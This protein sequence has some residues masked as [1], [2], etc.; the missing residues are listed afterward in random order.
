MTAPT[1]AVERRAAEPPWPA[2]WNIC[3]AKKMMELIP[4]SCWNMGR[5]T[6]H[7]HST[8]ISGPAA[9]HQGVG[10]VGE[11]HG[12]EDEEQG[13]DATQA[14]ADAPAVPRDGEGLVVDELCDEDADGD[15]ELIPE[16]VEGGR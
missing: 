6:V 10:G 8:G 12:A 16:Q 9:G 11:G 13:R 2:A 4:V 15:G 7:Q 3:G 1:M 5:R 14:E